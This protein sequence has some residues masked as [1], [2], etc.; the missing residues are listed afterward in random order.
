MEEII[1]LW[2]GSCGSGLTGFRLGGGSFEWERD[3]LKS[4]LG[5]EM[6]LGWKFAYFV[7]SCCLLAKICVF[8][9]NF[10]V[11]GHGRRMTTESFVHSL[12]EAFNC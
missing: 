9:L 10:V 8:F 6:L 3:D 5:A 1:R 2:P 12:A 7:T 11:S 4:D